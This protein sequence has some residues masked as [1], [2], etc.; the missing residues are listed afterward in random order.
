MDASIFKGKSTMKDTYQ[1]LRA[2]RR[3]NKMGVIATAWICA[4]REVGTSKAAE[5]TDQID[6]TILADF[7]R[8]WAMEDGIKCLTSFEYLTTA[9]T[10]LRAFRLWKAIQ[11]NN[12][13]IAERNSK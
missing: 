12:A 1:T 4:V 6:Q 7:D 8:R 11:R 13:L 2:A 3:I 5:M 9:K 10:P